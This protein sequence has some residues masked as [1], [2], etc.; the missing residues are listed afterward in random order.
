MTLPPS[1]AIAMT[2]PMSAAPRKL[3]SAAAN[4]TEKPNAHPHS[5]DI[6]YVGTTA[7]PPVIA[8][9][10]T[11]SSGAALAPE[12]SQVASAPRRVYSA[13]PP[14][15]GSKDVITAS[16]PAGPSRRAMVRHRETVA[17]R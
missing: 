6:A 3:Q 15:T 12:R 17:A 14:T 16:G 11:Q 10:A 8:K 13:A 2:Y 4:P 9:T 5:T 7:S 1:A